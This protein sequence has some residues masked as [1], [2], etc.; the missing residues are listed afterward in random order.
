MHTHVQC[1]SNPEPDDVGE[2]KES[3]VQIQ[4]MFQRKRTHWTYGKKKHR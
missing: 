1:G 4:D 2:K 3:Q